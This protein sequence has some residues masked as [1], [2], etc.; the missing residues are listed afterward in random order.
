MTVFSLHHGV[1][2]EGV[3][4]SLRVVF[5]G[6]PHRHHVPRRLEEDDSIPSM[7]AYLS[8]ARSR[9]LTG[10]KLLSHLQDV[11]K[12]SGE[13]RD[14]FPQGCRVVHAAVR[15]YSPE[16]RPFSDWHYDL[17]DLTVTFFIGSSVESTSQ[18][19][20]LEGGDFLYVDKDGVPA[21]SALN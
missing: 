4:A 21:P 10:A 11:V 2:S 1:L 8:D 7:A 20:S 18:S 9:R 12:A 15:K 3:C 6:T 17:E 16:L 14:Y 19:A 5:E 13:V